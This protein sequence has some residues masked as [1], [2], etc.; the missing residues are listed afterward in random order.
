MRSI[1]PP[2]A[3][4]AT[5]SMIPVAF[6]VAYHATTPAIPAHGVEAKHLLTLT[7]YVGERN[8]GTLVTTPAEALA[9]GVAPVA[10]AEALE[11]R[12]RGQG[13]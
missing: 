3:T 5:R 8:V 11:R 2:D 10:V 4:V 6:S 9:L 7:T 12:G 13:S 1:R